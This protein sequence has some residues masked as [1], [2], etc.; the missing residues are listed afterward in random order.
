MLKTTTWFSHGM[1]S[2][3]PNEWP[4][5]STSAPKRTFQFSSSTELNF[6]LTLIVQRFSRVNKICKPAKTWLSIYISS[7]IYIDKILFTVLTSCYLIHHSK[8]K[9]KQKNALRECTHKILYANDTVVRTNISFLLY[10]Q[11]N[12]NTCT[13]L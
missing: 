8:L 13:P 9:C 12:K 6:K 3:A 10:L 11:P 5:L 4:I 7:W 2:K 1:F